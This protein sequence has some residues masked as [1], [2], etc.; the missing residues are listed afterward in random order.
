[1]YGI[2]RCRTGELGVWVRSCPNGHFAEVN[3]CSCRERSCP[4]CAPA[5]RMRWLE[6]WSQRL[7]PGMHL[8]TVLTLPSELH[9]VW[10]HNRRA[11]ARMLFAVARQTLF[12]LTDDARHLGALP[13]MLMALHTW[14][15]ELSLH[16]H[17]HI[18]VSGGG[19]DAGGQWKPLT[20]RDFLAPVG[21][22]RKLFCRQFLDALEQA[23]KRGEVA[24][25]PGWEEA[26]MRGQIRRL[27]RIKWNV[28][29][30]PPYR[31]GRGVTNY[32]ARY[33]MGGPIGRSRLLSFDGKEVEFV[34]GREARNPST[35]K[36]EVE[37]F[38]RRWFQHVPVRGL[39]TVRAYGLYAS[40]HGE[41]REACRAMIV[42]EVGEEAAIE[43][44]RI[45]ALPARVDRC[46]I[47]KLELVIE[48]HRGRVPRQHGPPA[49]APASLPFPQAA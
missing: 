37:E 32:L 9:D 25:P 3:A 19:L 22:L 15:R 7:L 5:R 20:R 36:L 8:H 46:P 12:T 39:H 16:P 28:R 45:E 6:G 1:M 17:L 24:R 41:K 38:L 4:M 29:I 47:C 30:E 49:R 42:G 43:A 44:T 27:R 11:M 35:R 48:E 2:M 31:H 34:V 23:Y 33:V 13:G 10:R 18:L 40:A 14:S 26:K 21:R